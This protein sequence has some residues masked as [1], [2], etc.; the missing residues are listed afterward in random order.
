M[1]MAR[2]GRPTTGIYKQ[3]S[4]VINFRIRP[5]TLAMLQAAA[6]KSGQ[7]LSQETE[8]QLRRALVQMGTG[9]TF[10]L[11]NLI[12]MV[13]DSAVNLQK[14]KAKW[15]NDPYLFDQ[16]LI[17]IISTLEA[18]RPEGKGLEPTDEVLAAGG[19]WQTRAHAFELLR[20]VQVAPVVPS[21]E[22]SEHQQAMAMIRRDLEMLADRPRPFGKTADQHRRMAA[23][24]SRFSELMR[25][26]G[27]TPDEMTQQEWKEL[28][29]LWQRLQRMEEDATSSPRKPAS[30]TRNADH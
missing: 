9:P 11:L 19:R 2:T 12:A 4:K 22:G 24:A 8:H 7:T 16:A 25:K 17:A 6:K 29:G 13:I 30:V 21:L 18:F 27:K 23:I 14:P 20:Q 28:H 3:K 15:F 5:D 10:A 26:G 1:T